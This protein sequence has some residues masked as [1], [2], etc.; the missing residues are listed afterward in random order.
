MNHPHL[1][2][3]LRCY[4]ARFSIKAAHLALLCLPFLQTHAAQRT[5]DPWSLVETH[6]AIEVAHKG[7]LVLRYHKQQVVAPTGM[8][9][10]VGMSGFVHPLRTLQGVTVTEDFAEDHPHHSGL[11]SAW[12]NTS[13]AGRSVDFWNLHK[14]EGRVEHREVLWIDADLPAFQV[15]KVF[16]DL[17][18][19]QPTDRLEEIWS[20]CN[21]Q[22]EQEGWSFEIHCR[23]RLIGDEPVTLEVYPYGGLSL[24]FPD[25]W[26]A[27][28]GNEESITVCNDAGQDRFESNQ[29]LARWILTTGTLEAQPVSVLSMMHPESMRFPQALR[30]HP[31]MPYFVWTM[32]SRNP[33]TFEHDTH[34]QSRFRYHIAD[35]IL[36]PAAAAMAF[37]RYQEQ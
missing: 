32:P 12:A 10:S 9:A 1:L 28:N 17:T 11:W 25:T 21:F 26:N 15:R 30:Y 23:Q 16:V 31:T 13:I 24:R 33:F 5:Q 18:P 14:R 20:F 36:Q 3:S 4:P 29:Q 34:Y 6:A 27:A 37:A 19:G 8:D 22:L 2:S 35:A 7:N